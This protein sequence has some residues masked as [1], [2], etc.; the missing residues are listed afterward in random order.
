MEVE[1]SSLTSK[2]IQYTS[3]KDV[4]AIDLEEDKQI[5]HI[6]QTTK[7]KHSRKFFLLSIMIIILSFVIIIIIIKPNR[8]FMLQQSAL[9]K[10]T[11]FK[12]TIHPDPPN[13]LWGTVS[14]PYPTGAFWT[15]LVIKNGD[16]AIAVYPYGIKAVDTGIQVSYGAY[17]RVVTSYAITDPFAIDLQVSSLQSIIN[18]SIESY[19]NLSV[20]MAYKTSTNGK[21]RAVLVKS[22]P[23]VTILFDNTTPIISSPI[24]KYISVDAKVVKDYPGTQYLVTLG[25]NQ[26]WLVYCSEPIALTWKENTLVAV[27]PIKGY[28]RIAILPLQNPE[29]AFNLLLGYVMKYPTGGN[30]TMT[31]PSPTQAILAI[32]YTTVGTGP[33]LMLALPH[34]LPLLGSVDSDELKRVQAIYAPIYCIKGHMRPILGD[35]WK[36]AYTMPSLGWH[37]TLSDKLSTSQLDEIARYLIVEVK[38]NIPMASDVYS[39]GK[40]LGRMA[41]LALIADNLGK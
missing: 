9:I 32:A 16:G 11:P 3:I 31:Y 37:Y 5:D 35:V 38:S 23:F 7:S 41:R 29:A 24:M 21:F 2:H 18:H 8:L 33:L 14:K 12:Q 13:S 15:N 34:H 26:K 6:S 17:R 30:L 20:T 25:N 22:S 19:D 1:L 4:D 28:I 10:N 27:A 36:L 39:F 40:Q